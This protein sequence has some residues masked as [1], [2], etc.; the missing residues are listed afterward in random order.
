MVG[1]EVG[2]GFLQVSDQSCSHSS[3]DDNVVDINFQVVADLLPETLLHAL[4]EGG[5][6]VPEAERHGSVAEGAEG[7]DE[8]HDHLIGGVHCNLVVLGV[9]I[10]KAKGLTA[11]GGINHLVNLRKG[12]RV[13]PN[14]AKQNQVLIYVCPGCPNIHIYHKL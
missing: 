13:T 4:L 10:Q 11:S 6:G 9:R 12:K 1:A 2:E 3:F 14:F 7:G 5:S 8:G